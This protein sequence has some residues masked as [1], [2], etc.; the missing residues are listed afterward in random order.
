MQRGQKRRAGGG[1]ETPQRAGGE[2][3]EEEETATFQVCKRRR[4]AHLS[5]RER[6]LR[7][8]IVTST[9]MEEK[10]FVGILVSLTCRRR[11]LFW[12]AVKVH[13]EVCKHSVRVCVWA[14]GRKGWVTAGGGRRV[15]RTSTSSSP[16]LC[17]T[18]L[19]SLCCLFSRMLL[20]PSHVAQ[21]HPTPSSVRDTK[22][23]VCTRGTYP[24]K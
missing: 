17:N 24:K 6:Q 21:T 16:T 7:R 22:Q 19:D 9:R 5:Q 14:G 10:Q 1:G 8:G 4:Q 12:K 3:K 11:L 13:I 20:C 15:G 18:S 2:K 23:Y